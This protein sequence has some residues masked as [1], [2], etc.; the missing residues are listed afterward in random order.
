MSPGDWD[1]A[2]W[3]VQRCYIEGLES[4]GLI[5]SGGGGEEA[6]REAGVVS[7]KADTGAAVIDLAR[8]RAALGG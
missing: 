1:S 3:H 6:A 5:S 8:M 2:G 7:R 4:E